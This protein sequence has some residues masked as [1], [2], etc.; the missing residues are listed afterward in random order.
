MIRFWLFIRVALLKVKNERLK[1]ENKFLREQIERMAK[2]RDLFQ[3]R[4]YD[5]IERACK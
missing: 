5:F 1:W 2:D 4:Y 3:N